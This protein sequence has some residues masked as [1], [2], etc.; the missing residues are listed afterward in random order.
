MPLLVIR[1][2]LVCIV[3]VPAMGL[4]ASAEPQLAKAACSTNPRPSQIQAGNWHVG[5]D[6]YAQ[7][8]V[9]GVYGQLENQAPYVYPSSMFNF[10]A[11]YVLIGVPGMQNYAQVG[12][13]QR[14]NGERNTFVQGVGS[15]WQLSRQ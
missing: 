4:V 7:T 13:I 9:G 10:S 1:L 15:K 8:T 5:M 11:A 2:L 12:W 14:R 6:N 3:S